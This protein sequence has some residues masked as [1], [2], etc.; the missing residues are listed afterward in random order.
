VVALVVCPLVLLVMNTRA[1]AM[2]P[3]LAEV[4][5]PVMAP[6][7]VSCANAVTAAAATA[8]TRQILPDRDSKEQNF[9]D[10]IRMGNFLFTWN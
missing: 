2:A 6:V 9:P 1:P 10:A 5:V 7:P 8:H 4:T 3:P